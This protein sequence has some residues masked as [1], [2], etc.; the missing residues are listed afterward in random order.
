M[1]RFYAFEQHGACAK[2]RISQ[3]DQAVRWK[4]WRVRSRERPDDPRSSSQTFPDC[5]RIP[6]L[7]KQSI[8]QP[9]ATP[10][11]AAPIPSLAVPI[12]GG[13][14]TLP[15]WP[16]APVT[17]TPPGVATRHRSGARAWRK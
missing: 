15:N 13:A 10:P 12:Q 7:N 3:N 9:E 11:S 16:A 6:S 4:A 2:G 8:K 14:N 5:R 17:C 1:I